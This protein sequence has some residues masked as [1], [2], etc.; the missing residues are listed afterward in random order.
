ML[1]ILN[2]VALSLVLASAP[3]SPATAARAGREAPANPASQ[4]LVMLK[5]PMEHFRPEGYGG[6]YGDGE[7][8]GARWRI[9]LRLAREQGISVVDEWPMPLLGVDC[10]LMTV[11][12]PRSPEDVAL[13]LSHSPGVSWSEPLHAYRGQGASLAGGDA[14]A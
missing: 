12:A 8:R 6:S 4:V 7:G 2:S 3:A 10:Y 9:A 14:P 11:P 5:M 1:A 13:K